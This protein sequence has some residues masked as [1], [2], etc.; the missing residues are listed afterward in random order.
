MPTGW[1]CGRSHWPPRPRERTHR[2]QMG[3]QKAHTCNPVL[4]RVCRR[5]TGL[6]VL[7]LNVPV[8]HSGQGPLS[9][10]LLQ[11]PRPLDAGKDKTRFSSGASQ[12]NQPCPHSTSAQ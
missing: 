1:P 12:R 10:L 7:L 4:C 2:L 9:P 3:T 8:S 11:L 6:S 5:H